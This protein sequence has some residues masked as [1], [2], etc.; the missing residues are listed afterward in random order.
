MKKTILSQLKV[1]ARPEKSA[2]SPIEKRRSR[3]M[4]RLEEQLQI[5]QSRI[6][7]THCTFYKNK[8]V[9]N[10]DTGERT[11]VRKIRRVPAWFYEAEGKHYF[12]LRYGTKRLEITKGKPAIEAPDLQG[13]EVMIGQLIEATKA[14]ELDVLIE[15]VDSP[16]KVNAK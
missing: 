4:T 10:D 15:A 3:L 8:W 5:V 11:Q 1:V 13:I 7:E 14:G 6:N 16:F 2:Q 12:E 9:V